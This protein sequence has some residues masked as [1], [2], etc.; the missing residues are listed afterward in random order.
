MLTQGQR[1]SRAQ[2][3]NGLAAGSPGDHSQKTIAGCKVSTMIESVPK[4]LI[5]VVDDDPSM[6]DV[7]IKG[8]TSES[9][10]VEAA[11]SAQV[12]LGRIANSDVDAVVTDL[13]M[14]GLSGLDLCQHIVERCG[15]IPVIVF[16]AFGDYETAVQALRV[17]AYDFLSKPVRL[18]VLALTIERAL[19]HVRLRR[20]VR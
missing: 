6:R 13:R 1:V 18:D 2:L 9:L 17:G 8:L 14:P 3:A 7:L 19:S 11:E 5:L 15:D 16:T 10:A 12:A 4:S 20:E